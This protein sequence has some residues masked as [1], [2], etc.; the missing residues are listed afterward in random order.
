MADNPI[1]N[2]KMAQAEYSTASQAVTS[3]QQQ[4]WNPEL[5]TYLSTS[6]LIFTVIGLVLATTLLWRGNA[7][8]QFVLKV[9]GVLFIIG[10]SAFLLVVGY[11]NAQLTPI[12]GLFGAIAGYL[13]GKETGNG[14]DN[15]AG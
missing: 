4:P 15:N 10:L 12:V 13:L 7:A 6:I 9:F 3:Q 2:L 14:K 1:A 8:P 5:A 11:S